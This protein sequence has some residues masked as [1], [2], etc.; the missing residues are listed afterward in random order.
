[1]LNLN[2]VNIIWKRKSQKWRY[3]YIFNVITHFYSR[4][5]R[6]LWCIKVRAKT[7][8]CTTTSLSRTTVYEECK[9]DTAL[10]IEEMSFIS[11]SLP[12][13]QAFESWAEL[14]CC[15]MLHQTQMWAWCL[16]GVGQSHSSV[17]GNMLQRK[18]L[19]NIF[20][21]VFQ[22][23]WILLAPPCLL[24]AE[25]SQNC[26]SITLQV[27]VENV[28]VQNS[29]KSGLEE[30]QKNQQRINRIASWAHSLPHLELDPVNL[31]PKFRLQLRSPHQD[32]TNCPL[33]SFGQVFQ[34]I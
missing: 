26:N 31:L 2:K 17:K 14:L 5:C 20:Q 12:N 6:I 18:K 30:A 15:V 1:M 4:H 33:K 24:T 7:W 3:A 27:S 21:S 13:A 34:Y 22:C 23:V 9:I 25:Q 19:W 16:S 29:R 11:M 28:L 8:I 10:L 32:Q